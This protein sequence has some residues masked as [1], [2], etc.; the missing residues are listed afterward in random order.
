VGPAWENCIRVWLASFDRVAKRR[1][2]K[3]TLVHGGQVTR[4]GQTK[5]PIG[6]ADFIADKIAREIGW[7][8]ETHE[9]DWDALGSAAGPIRNQQMAELNIDRGYA[10]GKLRKR[11]AQEKRSGTGGMVDILNEKGIVVTV[12]ASATSMPL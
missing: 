2:W 10:F 6:G 4:D 9:A 3:V 1:G 12:V 5:K 7:D 8:I 11:P